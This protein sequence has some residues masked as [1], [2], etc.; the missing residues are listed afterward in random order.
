[1]KSSLAFYL[2][3]LLASKLPADVRLSKV[4][5][6]H[7]VLQ[8][9]MAVPVWGTATPGETVTVS[10][11]GQSKS[12]RADAQ[13]NWRVKLDPL[14][15]SA[16]SRTLMI[17]S[18]KIKDVLVGDVWLGSGQSNMDMEAASYIKDDPVLDA[19]VQRTYPQLRL[20]RKE[21]NATWEESSAETNLKFSALLFSFG[22]ALQKQIG[23]PVGLMVGAVSGTPSVDWLTEEMWRSD[24]GCE[25]TIKKYYP[26]Y[27]YEALVAKYN[28][29]MAKHA[30]DLAA[31]KKMAAA[32]QRKG[33]SPPPEPRA[34]DPV[35]KVAG[36][37]SGT[38]GQHYEQFIRPYVGYG[39]KGVVW[40]QGESGTNIDFVSHASLMG[41]LINGWRKDWGQGGFP[42]IYI[43]KPS[44]G[45]CAF[46]YSRPMNRLAEKFAPLPVK[47]PA[48]PNPYN[49]HV[50]FE[51]IMKYKNTHMVIS[52]D[53]GNGIHPPNKSGYG[54]RAV[55]VALA[56]VY[57][58]GNEYLGP[59]LASHTIN[60]GKVTLKFKHMGKGLAFKN[61]NKLQ[62]FM[63]AGG[64]KKFVW[65]DAVIEGD[66]VIVSSKD[67]PEPAAVRY[68]WSDT[69][70][71]A[72]LFN[73]D[74]LPSQPFRTD[75][76]Q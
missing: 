15:A 70:Q 69:F 55:Q 74:G 7:M 1:M 52:S 51:Q 27:N 76:W 6:P 39:I 53:L 2:F 38:I 34:P 73:R 57:D 46:D 30:V 61:G 64:D 33:N 54:V 40:D 50:A 67:V 31:W 26:N 68:A 12:A 22:F 35:R 36:A 8:R 45:G 24:P 28:A 37:N 19:A 66:S 60:E 21:G 25:E 42:W 47:I 71:W 56:A 9:G 17:G 10:F 13:G 29:D 72:N 41:A 5:T 14:K 18:Y 49:S 58:Q 63:I 59:Q 62:G 48:P 16:E 23:V 44:G 65:A 20:L 11:A 3:L 32:A 43:E 4:F 75:D